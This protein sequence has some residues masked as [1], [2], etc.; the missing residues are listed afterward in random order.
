MLHYS[1]NFFA[2]VGIFYPF[3]PFIFLFFLPATGSQCG[4]AP[5]NKDLA[6]VTWGGPLKAN[7]IHCSCV[8]G[9]I[10]E[11]IRKGLQQGCQTILGSTTF[12]LF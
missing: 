6:S 10:K 3:V 11:H 7:Q 4:K 2:Q 12:F 8:P 1:G 5:L 9:K